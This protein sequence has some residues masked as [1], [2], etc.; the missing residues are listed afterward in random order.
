MKL[1]LKMSLRRFGVD[2]IQAWLERLRE[3]QIRGPTVRALLL[4]GSL[5]T[6][7][8]SSAPKNGALKLG[9]KMTRQRLNLGL[10][11]LCAAGWRAVRLWSRKIGDAGRYLAQ[12]FDQAEHGR[13]RSCSL[14][15]LISLCESRG[16]E[17]QSRSL[18]HSRRSFP[19]GGLSG[20][21]CMLIT[22]RRVPHNVAFASCGSWNIERRRIVGGCGMRVI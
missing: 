11:L 20:T 18:R 6:N 21:G 1:S 9:V 13:P 4:P 10:G 17:G 5:R 2:S 8:S 15:K 22:V 16:R 19:S 3:F 7:A 14:M 12:L